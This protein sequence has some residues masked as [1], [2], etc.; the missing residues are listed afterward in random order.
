MKAL[1]Q[2]RARITRVREVQLLHAVGEAAAAEGKVA[3]LEGNAAKLAAMRMSLT[4]APGITTGA[5][6]GNAGEMGLRLDTVRHGLTDAIGA[7]KAI[8]QARVND[9]RDADIRRESAERLEGRAVIELQ[10][11]IEERMTANFRR[12]PRKEAPNA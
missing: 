6:I 9:R 10:R 2:R 5:G 1:A 12:R 4:L 7:A 11:L 8:A 3:Q